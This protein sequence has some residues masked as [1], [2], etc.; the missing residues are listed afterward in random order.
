VRCAQTLPPLPLL[1]SGRLTTDCANR[2]GPARVT[3]RRNAR[4]QSTVVAAPTGLGSGVA[5]D[6]YSGAVPDRDRPW[7]HALVAACAIPH[8]PEYADRAPAL[9]AF[10]RSRRAGEMT[11]RAAAADHRPRDGRPPSGH[12]RARHGVAS[13]QMRFET[14]VGRIEVRLD[15]VRGPAKNGVRPDHAERGE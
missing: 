7:R 1:N 11:R 13:A 4:R 14:A 5:P 15:A 12:G 6:G 2:A 3:H 10:A 8:H 9:T